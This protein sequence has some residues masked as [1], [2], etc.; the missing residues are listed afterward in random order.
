LVN[1]FHRKYK[2]A[3]DLV[4]INV[5][6]PMLKKMLDWLPQ[7]NPFDGWSIGRINLIFDIFQ[8]ILIMNWMNLFPKWMKW[9]M[10]RKKLKFQQ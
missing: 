5:L 3:E 1:I 2:K 7:R 10:K 6:G 9:R 8:L 4:L